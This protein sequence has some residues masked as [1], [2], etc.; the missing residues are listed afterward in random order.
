MTGR[1]CAAKCLGYL[2]AIQKYFDLIVNCVIES[3]E[4]I[5][6]FNKMNEENEARFTAWREKYVTPL[7]G[8]SRQ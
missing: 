8:A 3:D 1:V 2:L 6:E 7:E 4:A 5:D